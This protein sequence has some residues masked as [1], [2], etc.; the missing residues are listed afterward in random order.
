MAIFNI[1]ICTEVQMLHRDFLGLPY[2]SNQQRIHPQSRD[3]LKK[4]Y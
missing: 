4:V 1:H 2:K 3:L